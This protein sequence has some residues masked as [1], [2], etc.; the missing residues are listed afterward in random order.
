MFVR[1][2]LGQVES[3]DGGHERYLSAFYMGQLLYFEI[4]YVTLFLLML[5]GRELFGVCYHVHIAM[6]LLPL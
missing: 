4:V 6:C 5:K 1:G 2:L 3:I